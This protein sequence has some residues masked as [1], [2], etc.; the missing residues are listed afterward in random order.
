MSSTLWRVIST[1]YWPWHLRQT[2]VARFP[3]LKT[4]QCGFGTYKV[5]ANL[6]SLRD[7]PTL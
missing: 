1:L 7:M 5:D 2:G 4:I 6:N 3:H